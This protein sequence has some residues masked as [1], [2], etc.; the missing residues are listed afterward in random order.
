MLSFGE[1]FSYEFIKL[2]CKYNNINSIFLDAR[3]LIITNS[4]FGNAKPIFELC[5]RNLNSKIASLKGK[6][7]FIQGFIAS[8]QEGNTTT[9][10]FESSNLTATILAKTFN[11]NQIEIVTDVEGIRDVDPKMILFSK[12]IKN[13]DYNF[14]Y[15]LAESGL[16]LLFKDMILIAETNDIKIKITNLESKVYTYIYKDI[17]C[18][19][20]MLVLNTNKLFGCIVFDS[21]SQKINIQKELT[22]Y[23]LEY[24]SINESI[25]F[26]YTKGFNFKN[27]N[28]DYEKANDL[29]EISVFNVNSNQILKISDLVE[30]KKFLIQ[31]NKTV[32]VVSTSDI[33]STI[34]NIYGELIIEQS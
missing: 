10:G 6:L 12:P 20:K 27:F 2:I 9:M 22:K 23:N 13:I 8:S 24:F 26:S 31:N 5:E 33:N 32:F 17:I 11:I 14:A 29:F 25:L 3:E 7:Y 1:I 18:N 19:E 16:N 34:N 28:F 4:D 15:S 30:I 21:L